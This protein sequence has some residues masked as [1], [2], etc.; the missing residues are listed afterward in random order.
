M[1]EGVCDLATPLHGARAEVHDWVAGREGDFREA[2]DTLQRARGLRLRLTVWT[3]LTRSNARVLGEIP[4]LIK[5]RGAIDWV[6]VFPSTEG[7]APPFT[8]VVP[9]YGMAIPAAL[10]ALEAARRR[11]LGTRIAG[12]PRCVLG[13]FASRAIPSPTR[14]YARSCAGCPSKAGCPG[15]DAA[16]LARFGAGELRPAPDVALEPW[17]PFE[18]RARPP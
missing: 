12:A 6:I 8:R 14:S 18:A 17:M 15:T 10:A 9:R 7:L 13:H 2:L 5:A 11:G 16:Y 4:S 1:A 3:R